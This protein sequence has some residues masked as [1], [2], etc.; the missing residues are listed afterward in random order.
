MGIVC[1]TPWILLWSV[2]VT[3]CMSL[4]EFIWSQDAYAACVMLRVCFW[5]SQLWGLAQCF[6]LEALLTLSVCV[7]VCLCVFS[8]LCIFLSASSSLRLFFYL[9]I[10][11]KCFLQWQQSFICDYIISFLLFPSFLI[12]WLQLVRTG[13][14]QNVWS[15]ACGKL[16]VSICSRRGL[17]WT[18]FHK[19][20]TFISRSSQIEAD[21]A[22]VFSFC[23]FCIC[24]LPYLISTRD[25]LT[26]SLEPLVSVFTSCHGWRIRC[27]C[28]LRFTSLLMVFAVVTEAV[29]DNPPHLDMLLFAF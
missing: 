5:W 17:R 9:N 25:V 4:E 28:L 27:G 1:V 3:V 6:S 18:L 12:A 2:M 26:E 22:T 15:L 16:H 20:F 29:F 7:F 8:Y 13:H 21:L 19:F 14:S 11:C 23:H 24:F 10:Y